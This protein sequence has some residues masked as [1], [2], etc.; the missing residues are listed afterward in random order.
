ML[1]ST[2]I[3][4]ALTSSCTGVS[5]CS[6]PPGVTEAPLPTLVSLTR[7]TPRPGKLRCFAHPHAGAA[8]VGC[9]CWLH[10]LSWSRYG[11]FRLGCYWSPAEAIRGKSAIC[12]YQQMVAWWL[13]VPQILMCGCG[14]CRC[15]SLQWTA[16]GCGG[17]A[18]FLL[19]GNAGWHDVMHLMCYVLLKGVCVRGSKEWL[20]QAMAASSCVCCARWCILC[21]ALCLSCMAS[22]STCELGC[23]VL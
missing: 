19:Q 23:V 12:P 14:A 5:T 18:D 20:Q 3:T 9:H 17:L 13:Q 7:L 15:V 1:C 8:A 4:R 2:A 21:I 16:S 11:A 6:C 22:A 10:L